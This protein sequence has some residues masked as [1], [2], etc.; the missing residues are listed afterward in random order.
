MEKVRSYL[1]NFERGRMENWAIEKAHSFIALVNER[2]FDEALLSQKLQSRSF[3]PVPVNYG[4][5]ELFTTL[6][7][8]SVPELAGSAD[9]ENFWKAAFSTPVGKPSPWIVQ[10]SKVLVLFPVE[11]IEVEDSKQ[12]TVASNYSEY[13]LDYMIGQSMQKF[14][15]NSPRMEDKFMDAYFR[16]FVGNNNQ[17]Q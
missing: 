4:S 13:W 7:S 9:N 10:G 5:I 17:D 11:E 15:M 16:F 2:G 3:G 1:R 14:F 8:Q 12:E 6:Q